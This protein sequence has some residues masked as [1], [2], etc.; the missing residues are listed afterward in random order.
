VVPGEDE[1]EEE[2]IVLTQENIDQALYED[3][4]DPCSLT[5]LTMNVYMPTQQDHIEEDDI[6]ITTIS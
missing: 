3:E 2:E 1:D 6:E 4:N 5:R